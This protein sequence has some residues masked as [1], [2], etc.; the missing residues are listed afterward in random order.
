[1][2]FHHRSPPIKPYLS[3]SQIVQLTECPAQY[4][5]DQAL[6]ADRSD[7]LEDMAALGE[8]AH[9]RYRKALISDPVPGAGDPS[10][11]PG[12][13]VRLLR[14]LLNVLFGR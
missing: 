2:N 11:R 10:R 6:G 5:F 12:L 8:Q 13:F 4:H 7:A 3:V 1:M 9:E 14:W